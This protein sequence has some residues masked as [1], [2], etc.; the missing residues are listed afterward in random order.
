MI[1]AGEIGASWGCG[2]IMRRALA[3]LEANYRAGPERK[4]I[5]P[6]ARLQKTS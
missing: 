4:L 2:R 1:S 3:K 6:A 5:L